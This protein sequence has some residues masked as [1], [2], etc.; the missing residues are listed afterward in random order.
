MDYIED[1]KMKAGRG[2]ADAMLA[3]ARTYHRG[4][5]VERD[6]SGALDWYLEAAFS[7]S[8]EAML[9]IAEMY[10]TGDGLPKDMAKASDWQARANKLM[11]VETSQ[12]NFK[13]VVEQQSEC[14]ENAVRASGR[15]AVNPEEMLAAGKAFCKGDG[16]ETDYHK[17]MECFRKAADAGNAQAMYEIGSLY[18]YGKGVKKKY[19]KALDWYL[20]A[21]ENGYARAFYAIGYMF[22]EGCGVYQDYIT[23]LEWFRKAADKGD[24]DAMFNIAVMYGKGQGVEQDEGGTL[25]WMRNSANAG[26]EQ[27][28]AVFD[29]MMSKFPP[30]P[31]DKTMD[32]YVDML[33]VAIHLKKQL[34]K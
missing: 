16:V 27:A 31:A 10:R 17:A 18:F 21:S 11:G 20:K 7:G 2:D 23:A 6:V 33:G 26:N 4:E 3:L 29:Q 25:C 12:E 8:A 15:K 28:K 32:E 1:L 22:Y 9:A 34:E 24:A 19:M 5:G 30:K 13:E 14:N